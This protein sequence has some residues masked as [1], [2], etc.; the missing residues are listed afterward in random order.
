MTILGPDGKTPIA[1]D[2]IPHVLT[3]LRMETD[4]A[5][6]RAANDDIQDAVNWGD[7]GC[8]SAEHFETDDGRAGFRVWIEEAAPEAVE[9]QQ[10]IRADLAEH[11]WPG[12][13]VRTEW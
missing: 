10:F 11:G 8:S 1:I 13:E 7:L 3:L 4:N 9:L 5:L 2:Q 12:V 6:D